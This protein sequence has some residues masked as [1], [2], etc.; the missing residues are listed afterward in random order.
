MN[1]FNKMKS[2]KK[3]LPWGVGLVL[4][5]GWWVFIRTSGPLA[6]VEVVVGAAETGTL[7]REVFG[8]GQIEA[9]RTYKIGP[10]MPGRVLSI[11][12][13]VGDV[14]KKDQLL[15]EMDPVDIE[16]KIRA[17]EA[18]VTGAEAG[19]RASEFALRELEARKEYAA[20]QA[21]R[22]SQ[23]SKSSAVSAETYDT[24]RQELSISEAAYHAGLSNL[25]AAR[26]NLHRAQE[27]LSVLREQFANLRLMARVSGLVVA[28]L[29]EPGTTVVAGQTVIE[30]IDPSSLW[31]SARFDQ[32]SSAGL[33]K[34]LPTEIVTRS[35]PTDRLPGEILRIEPLADAVTEELLAKIAFE[36]LPEPLPPVGELCEVT[37]RLDAADEAEQKLILPNSA[38]QGRGGET[39]VWVYDGDSVVPRPVRTGAQSLSGRIEILEGLTSED[40]VVL[41]SRRP[42]REGMNVRLVDSIS[43]GAR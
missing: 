42:L 21:A 4:L 7:R 26:H 29:A 11:E 25:D 9:R 34:G 32:I 6:P 15:G 36:T 2:W 12:V 19:L 24:K 22:Y 30:I 27:E 31:V 41:H 37:V 16:A 35:R 18:V 20:G 23:L 3:W 5:L 40:R 39:M 33:R 17:Q 38:L 1:V 8:I 43:G 10:T 28:R 13:D 14:V